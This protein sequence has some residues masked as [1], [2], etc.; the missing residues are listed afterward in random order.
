MLWSEVYLAVA[1]LANRLSGGNYGFLA[2]RP[3]L[4]S[5][6][7]FYS[8]TK[9][10]YVAQINL[11]AAVLFAL[12]LMPWNLADRIRGMRRRSSSTP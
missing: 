11:T 3:A 12:L 9:W 4:R 2:H 7:D 6:L 8:D 5:L 1:L 10:V